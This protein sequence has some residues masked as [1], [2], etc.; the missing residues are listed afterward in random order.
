LPPQCFDLGRG[1]IGVGRRQA[2]LLKLQAVRVASAR[3]RASSIRPSGHPRRARMSTSA[4]SPFIMR[5]AAASAISPVPVNRRQ[6][7]FRGERGHGQTGQ[8]RSDAGFR[9]ADAGPCQSALAQIEG[10]ARCRRPGSRRF[11]NRHRRPGTRH[12]C[13]RSR[14]RCIGRAGR[15]R[16]QR[17][18]DRGRHLQAR[19]DPAR[20]RQRGT[21]RRARFNAE[22][23][24]SSRSGASARRSDN[25]LDRPLLTTA[26]SSGPALSSSRRQPVERGLPRLGGAAALDRPTRKLRSAEGRAAR[27]TAR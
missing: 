8:R 1:V 26:R 12:R 23:A 27:P 9:R 6:A 14:S 11:R 10:A 21:G 13:R 24:A 2:R 17:G 25:S 3:T 5:S 18:E 22:T 7:A 16:P 15:D 4:A 19:V 20:H